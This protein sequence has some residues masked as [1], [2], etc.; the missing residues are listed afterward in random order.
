MMKDEDKTRDQLIKE[1]AEL[2]QQISDLET[3]ER[4]C[5]LLNH[6]LQAE[7]QKWQRLAFVD[8]LT[9]VANRRQFDEA[10]TA[11]WQEL[12]QANRPLS[13]ILADIDYFKVYNDTFGHPAGDHCLQLVAQALRNAVRGQADLV[14]RYGGEE[15]AVLLPHTSAELAEQVA[16][17]L[18]QAVKACKIKQ[19]VRVDRR[20]VT[21]SLGVVC[22]IPNLDFSPDTL[23]AAADAALY[24]AKFA[25]RNTVVLGTYEG[26]CMLQSAQ[27][28]VA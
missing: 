28:Q 18:R 4:Q 25:G 9:K 15:F 23:V 2:R 21:L 22:T 12:A 26:A 11:S 13:L 27:E 1:L 20:L 14:A 19:S 24:Q 16:Q 10:L 17:R 5:Q 8:D 7:H 3:R 6:H